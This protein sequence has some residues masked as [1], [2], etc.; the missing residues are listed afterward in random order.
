MGSNQNVYL[1]NERPKSDA[2]DLV[3]RI[4]QGIEMAKKDG[5]EW[6]LIVEDD[7]FYRADYFSR[8]IPF[9]DKYDFIGDEQSY[10][11]NIG[12][13]RWT[14]FTHKYRSSLFTTAFRI[15]AL[16]NFEWPKEDSVFLDIDLWKYARH[17]RRKFVDSGAIGIKH[18]FGKCGGK[19]H[20]MKLANADPEMKWL[21]KR[22]DPESL[23]FYKSLSVWLTLHPV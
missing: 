13:R 21:E 8:Y 7:D 5:F 17:K 14:L 1:M 2:V 10:Y 23:E 3:P 19:G 12:T 9:M 15:S 4:R 20:K 22:V 18:G 11:Y 16:D 6:A